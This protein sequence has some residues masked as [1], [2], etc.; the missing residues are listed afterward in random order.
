MGTVQA[1][2]RKQ[3]LDFDVHRPLLWN[4]KQYQELTD[5][6]VKRRLQGAAGLSSACSPMKTTAP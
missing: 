5:D 4:G 6:A 2:V 3:I 1:D